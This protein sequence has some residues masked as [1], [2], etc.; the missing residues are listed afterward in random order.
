MPKRTARRRGPARQGGSPEWRTRMAALVIVLAGAVA[1]GNSLHGPFVFDDYPTIENN[2]TIRHLWP[3]STVLATTRETPT[4]LAGRP[5]A[6]LSFAFNY[7]FGGLHV[8]GYHAVNLVLHLLAA[9]TLFGVLRRTTRGLAFLCALIWAVHPLN[10]EA[11]DYL[12]QR[13]ESLAGLFWLLTLYAA[14]RAWETEDSRM[15]QILAVA[16]CAS[17][18]A[19]K[20][21]AVTAPLMVALYDRV[22]VCGSFREAVERRGRLYTALAACWLVFA[23]LVWQAPFFHRDSF[24]APGGGFGAHVSSWTYLVNQAPMI[25]QYLRLSF[26]PR[27]LVLDYGAPGPLSVA[28]VW[29]AELLALYLLALTIAALA[30]LPRIGFWGAWFFITLAPASSIVPIPTEVGAERR[31][32]LPLVAVVVLAALAARAGLPHLARVMNRFTG[33]DGPAKAGNYRSLGVAGAAIVVIGLVIAT[34]QRNIEYQSA[35]S[36]WQTVIDRRPNPRA[37]ANFA[38]VLGD[39]GRI[40]EALAHLRTAAPE[41]VDARRLLGL[42]L[43]VRG[44]N[45]EAIAHLSEFARVAPDDPDILQV[46]KALAAAYVRVGDPGKAKQELE[47]LTARAPEDASGHLDLGDVL[48]SLRDTGG[49]VAQYRECLRLQPDDIGILT[50]VERALASIDRADEAVETLLAAVRVN[51]A[52]ATELPRSPDRS[53]RRPGSG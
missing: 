23:S 15:W 46:R 13:T 35:V 12:T 25:A 42:E 14:I 45:R 22:F 31:M 32:Y 26:L 36:I 41:F 18:I 4:P 49:A 19:T 5:L 33:G 27:A 20:E 47:A 34:W 30:P 48:L 3:L 38:A 16:A 7:A 39:A 8:E 10:S 44:D 29:R 17:G 37:H 52:R 51:L 9:L 43:L 50:R 21:S 6:S 40:E 11:V 24:S 53:T 1:Y 28:D 2:S